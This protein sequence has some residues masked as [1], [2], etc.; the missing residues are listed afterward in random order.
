MIFGA[1][2][3]IQFM[4]ISGGV[5][6]DPFVNLMSHNLKIVLLWMDKIQA[7]SMFSLLHLP[8]TFLYRNLEGK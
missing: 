1:P 3:T 2:V 5:F 6:L 4:Q 7:F 8:K